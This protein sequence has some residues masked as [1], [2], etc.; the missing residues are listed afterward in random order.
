MPPVAIVLMAAI[1]AAAANIITVP[2]SSAAAAAYLTERRGALATAGFASSPRELLLSHLG[3][4]GQVLTVLHDPGG[5]QVD[6][7]V[8]LRPQKQLMKAPCRK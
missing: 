5:D 8:F 4:W 3:D 2:A 1:A 6:D 7:L